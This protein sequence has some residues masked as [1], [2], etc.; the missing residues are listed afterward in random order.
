[1]EVTNNTNEKLSF[2]GIEINALFN[3]W[4]EFQ[5]KLQPALENGNVISAPFHHF[6]AGTDVYSIMDWFLEQNPFF[7]IQ[8]AVKTGKRQFTVYSNQSDPK[9]GK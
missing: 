3:L 2:S 4:D 7:A 6:P 9:K 1:M 5:P 8:P